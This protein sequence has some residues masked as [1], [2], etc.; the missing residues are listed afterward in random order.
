MVDGPE[1][2]LDGFV[3]APKAIYM[4]E[5]QARRAREEQEWTPASDYPPPWL[6]QMFPRGSPPTQQ[7]GLPAQQGQ[8]GQVNNQGQVNGQVQMSNKGR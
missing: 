3:A 6:M 7:R 5:D 4:K 2:L 8:Q 1:N